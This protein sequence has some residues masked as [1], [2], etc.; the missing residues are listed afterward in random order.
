MARL[1]LSYVWKQKEIAVSP[2]RTGRGERLRVRLP[3]VDENGQWLQN[4][5]RKAPGSPA[6]PGRLH[7]GPRL[8][9]RSMHA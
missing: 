7:L 2:R 8:A 4:G 5:W 9:R 1:N 3:F 6:S